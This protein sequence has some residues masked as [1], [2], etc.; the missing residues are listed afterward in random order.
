MTK[1]KVSVFAPASM[2]NVSVG[3]DILGLCVKTD[4]R[5]LGDVVSVEI[6]SENEFVLAGEFADVL[7]DDH[8][9]NLVLKAKKLFIKAYPKAKDDRLKLTLEKNLP[10]CS[11]LGSSAASVVAAVQAL[12]EFYAKPLSKQECLKLMGQCEADASGSVHYDNIAPSFLGGLTL[13]SNDAGLV[14]HLPWPS[15]WKITQN[16]H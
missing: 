13:C 16:K 5:R 7:P 14:H 11:G 15:E 4:E 1:K 10:I 8:E 6:S 2:G 3:F 9:T 12:N